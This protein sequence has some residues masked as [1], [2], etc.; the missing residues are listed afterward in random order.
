MI[1]V[2]GGSVAADQVRSEVSKLVGVN[3]RVRQP[4]QHAL[5]ELRGLDSITSIDDLINYIVLNCD[6]TKE[7]VRVIS[8]R[9]TYGETQAALVLMPL[10]SA[11]RATKNGRM[12]IGLVYSSA[13]ICKRRLRCYRCLQFGHESKSCSGP[14]NSKCC[15]RCGKSDHHAA[16]CKASVEDAAEFRRSLFP[17]YQPRK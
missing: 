2:T 4:T 12:R 1:Q 6:I 17:D 15:R 8:L 7:E 11:A 16:D 14:D 9:K 3:T 5:V 10:D 13:R